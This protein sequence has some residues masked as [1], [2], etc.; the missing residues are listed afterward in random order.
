MA[1]I[2]YLLVG[3]VFQNKLFQEEERSLV[4]HLVSETANVR[5]SAGERI[6]GCVSH[7]PFA[8]SVQQIAKYP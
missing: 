7:S 6:I 1:A 3:V 5:E 2:D 4:V 8:G